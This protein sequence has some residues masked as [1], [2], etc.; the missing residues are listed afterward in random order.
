MKP[1]ILIIED[2]PEV[3][4]LLT[5]VLSP[6][7]YEVIPALGGEKAL[8]LLQQA[9]PAI[10]LLDLA[11]PGIDGLQLLASIQAMPHLNSAK[12]VVITARPQMAQDAQQYAVAAIFFK[13][14][15]PN[16]LV[17]TIKSLL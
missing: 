13:P 7:G 10:I 3:I 5:R 17:N 15:R 9:V 11:M 2:E 6:A 12:I 4:T 16:H 1:S 14:I 8:D